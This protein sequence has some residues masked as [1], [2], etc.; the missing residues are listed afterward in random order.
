M[1]FGYEACGILA[2][3]SGTELAAPELE[4]EILTTAVPRKFLYEL[5]IRVYTLWLFSRNR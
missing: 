4:V 1:F 3:Q 2:P 5:L